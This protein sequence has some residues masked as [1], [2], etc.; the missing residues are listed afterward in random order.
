[1]IWREDSLTL[2]YRDDS[3]TARIGAQEYLLFKDS[4]TPPDVFVGEVQ[5]SSRWVLFSSADSTDWNVPWRIHAWDRSHPDTPPKEVTRYDGNSTNPGFPL[6]QLR[7]D[8]VIWTGAKGTDHRLIQMAELDRGRVTTLAEGMVY[9][10]QWVDDDM[11]VWQHQRPGR[12]EVLLQGFDLHAPQPKECTGSSP[13]KA[14][15]RDHRD[16]GP[17]RRLPLRPASSS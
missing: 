15:V 12:K 1:M 17:R 5:T 16:P 6:Q 2:A 3:L 10:P 13:S 4:R 9:R 14:E 8:R 7:G 11:I